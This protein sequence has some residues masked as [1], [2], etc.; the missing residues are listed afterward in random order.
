MRALDFPADKRPDI[1]GVMGNLGQPVFNAPLPN[2]WPDT[3]ADWA[4]PEAMLR[5]V[6]WAYG[7]AGR[8]RDDAIPTQVADAMR[9]ARCC[10]PDTLEQVRRA[11]SRR[12][13]LTLVLASPEFLRR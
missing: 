12:D 2:G 11:G 10:T 6:D 8:A 3:A 9:S 1:T 4:A 13:A 5:R 7:V